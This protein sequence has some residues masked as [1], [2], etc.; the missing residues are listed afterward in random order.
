MRVFKTKPFS[1]F[2]NAED[3]ADSDLCEVVKRAEAGTI[4]ADLGGGVIKQRIARAGQGKSGGFRSIILYRRGDKAFFVHGFAKKD[5]DNIDSKELRA[6]RNLA[7]IMLAM[8]D[9][10]IKA[11]LKNRTITEVKCREA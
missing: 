3:I 2:A 9:E 4:D 5:K 10:Q 6:I 11:A 8:S 7:D 1:R